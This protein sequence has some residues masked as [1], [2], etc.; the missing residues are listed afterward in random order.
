M[1]TVLWKFAEN[2]FPDATMPT[3]R[4]CPSSTNQNTR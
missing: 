1:L 4:R 2:R 3:F